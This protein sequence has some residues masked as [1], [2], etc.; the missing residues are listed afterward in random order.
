MSESLQNKIGLNV[1][2]ARSLTNHGAT[3]MKEVR[4]NK[5]SWD[6]NAFELSKMKQNGEL[7]SLKSFYSDELI[8]DV[9]NAYE[10]DLTLYKEKFGSRNLMFP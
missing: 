5:V 10:P 1:V 7:P 9:R 2:D 8:Q 4:V 6:I 3:H